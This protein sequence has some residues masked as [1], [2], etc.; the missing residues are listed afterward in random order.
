MTHRWIVVETK[1]TLYQGH[2][3]I[4][5]PLQMAHLPGPTVIH[6]WI[7]VSADLAQ[8]FFLCSFVPIVCFPT[9]PF[10]LMTH[11]WIVIDKIY[12]NMLYYIILYHSILYCIVLYYMVLILQSII[13]ILYQERPRT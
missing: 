10:F 7:V 4:T 8:A 3:V 9:L 13:L 1:C 12:Y 6:R 11:R 5:V 2:A